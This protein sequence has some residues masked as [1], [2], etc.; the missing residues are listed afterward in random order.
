MYNLSRLTHVC[1]FWRMALINQPRMWSTVFITQEDRRSFV[2]MCLQRSHPAPLSIT[3]NAFEVAPAHPECECDKDHRGRLLPNERTPCEWHF[4]FEPLAESTHRN[5]VRAL[6]I[7]FDGGRIYETK[8]KRLVL[9]S[10]RFFTLSF[11]TLATLEW[12]NETKENAEYLFSTP[13]FPP[14]LRSLTFTG[15][16]SDMVMQ[17]NNLTSFTFEGD[18]AGEGISV[19]EVRQFLSNNQ[20]LESL[21]FKFVDFEGDPEGPPVHLSNLKSLNVGLAYKELSTVIR[22][23]AL[24]RLSFLRISA[25]SD[26]FGYNL[27][28]TGESI[29][30][31]ARCLSNEFGEIWECFTGYA[32]PVIRHVRLEEELRAGGRGDHNNAFISVLSDAHTLEIGCGYFPFWY[33]EFMEDLEQLGSH[34][35]VIRFAIPEGLFDGGDDGEDHESSLLDPIEEL[36]RNRLDNGRPFSAVERMVVGG[37]ERSNRQQDFMWRCFYGSRKL[38]RY[39]RST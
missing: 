32:K 37:S 17:V 2:D 9:G 18:C 20:S 35:K 13:P 4:Q 24:S 19:E 30:F 5:R 38:G 27:C 23:P 6:A 15:A 8:S 39:V 36:V 28:A 14:S 34:L 33:D 29:T 25:W 22:V 11:P 31:S 3:L 12:E 21:Q 7:N 16:W 10:C 26:C 1:R